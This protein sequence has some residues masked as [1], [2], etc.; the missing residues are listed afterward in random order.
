MS[1]AQPGG[2]WCCHD[3]C[4]LYKESLNQLQRAVLSQTF[5]LSVILL[6][7]LCIKE[8]VRGSNRKFTCE[9]HCIIYNLSHISHPDTLTQQAHVIAICKNVFKVYLYS[10]FEQVNSNFFKKHI[11]S[12]KESILSIFVVVLSLFH[13]RCKSLCGLFMCICS[14]FCISL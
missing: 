9:S 4:V 5:L 3:F 10:T 6:T 11:K 2:V 12:I 8:S 7:R 13:S 1:R 14:S